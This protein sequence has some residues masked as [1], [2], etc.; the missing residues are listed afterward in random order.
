VTGKPT[1]LI[2]EDNLDLAE[3]AKRFLEIKR[4]RVLISDGGNLQEILKTEK[5][6]IIIL[7]IFLGRLDGREICRELKQN[8]GTKS[9]PV[10]MLSAHDRLSKAYDDDCADG[11]IMKPFALAELLGEIKLLIKIPDAE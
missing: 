4:F 7:D 11:Y 6:D 10:I 8:E 3:A 5:P 1:V 2:V 9:I